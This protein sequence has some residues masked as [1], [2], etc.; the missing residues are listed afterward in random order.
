MPQGRL[1][2]FNGTVRWHYKINCQGYVQ[3]DVMS[4]NYKTKSGAFFRLLTQTIEATK[5]RK[6][7]FRVTNIQKKKEKIT[8]VSNI[9][10]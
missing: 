9:E 2:L 4:G 3:T 6:R 8:A 10:I 7:I 1:V 5:K